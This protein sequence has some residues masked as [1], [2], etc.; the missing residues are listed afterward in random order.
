MTK[1]QVIRNGEVLAAAPGEAIRISRKAAQLTQ[2]QGEQLRIYACGGDGTL[3][4][5]VNGAAGFDNVAVTVFSGGS[6]NDFVKIFDEPKAFFDLKSLD[7][8]CLDLL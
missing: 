8:S 3:N 1:I 6:G 7:Q 4:E 5:V 2:E